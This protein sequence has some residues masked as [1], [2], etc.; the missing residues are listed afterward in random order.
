MKI[1]IGAGSTNYPGFLNCDY[2]DIFNPEYVFDLERDVFPFEDNSV[3]EVIF[4][5][6]ASGRSS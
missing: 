1:N 6:R 5:N 2:S 4:S 3:D